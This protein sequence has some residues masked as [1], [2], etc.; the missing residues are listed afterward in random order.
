MGNLYRTTS[1]KKSLGQGM[2]EFAIVGPIFFLMLFGVIELGRVMFV[3]HQVSNGAREGARWAMVRGDLS[4]LAIDEAD[5]R[6]TVLNRT[7]GLDPAQLDV[8]ATWPDGNRAIG[9]QI[10]VTLSYNYV[11][12]IS[13]IFNTG[14]FTISRTSTVAIQY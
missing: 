10:S 6:D 13:N 14:S 9:S 12:L 7:S 11:P 8:Q 3:T 4:G 1:G 5:I 2:V